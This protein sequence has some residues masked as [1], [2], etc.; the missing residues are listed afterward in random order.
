LFNIDR[1]IT[2]T[3]TYLVLFVEQYLDR[4]SKKAA[5]GLP[6]MQLGLLGTVN[7]LGELVWQLLDAE[8]ILV[9][10]KDELEVPRLLRR[11]RRCKRRRKAG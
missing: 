4:S 11:R 5:A 10:A 8:G 3:A 9:D 2:Q 7:K 6:Q 1:N